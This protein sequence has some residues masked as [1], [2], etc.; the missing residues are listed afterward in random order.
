MHAPPGGQ[1]RLPFSMS[2]PTSKV[3]VVMSGNGNFVVGT[4]K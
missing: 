1:R 4:L 3:C 2:C